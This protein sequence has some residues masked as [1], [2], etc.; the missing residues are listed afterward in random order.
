MGGHL[1]FL[2]PHSIACSSGFFGNVLQRSGVLG[3]LFLQLHTH[4]PALGPPAS[5]KGQHQGY[6]D[7]S[8]LQLQ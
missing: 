7:G 4:A 6:A 2:F 8:Q 3:A 5:G 1:A